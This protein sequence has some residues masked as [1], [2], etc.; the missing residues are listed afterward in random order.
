MSK[1]KKIIAFSG[2]MLY[3]PDSY[4]SLPPNTSNVLHLH[5]QTRFHIY[6]NLIMT[7]KD[8]NNKFIVLRLPQKKSIFL[9][10]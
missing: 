4:I 10:R 1:E 5:L 9:K 6:T 7:K 2:V 8:S 3:D